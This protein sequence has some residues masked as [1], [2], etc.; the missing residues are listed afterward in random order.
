[1]QATT[2]C[3]NCGTAFTGHYCTNCGEKAFTSHDRSMAH[4]LEEG[5]HFMTHF[6]GKLFT[7]VKTMFTAPGKF[8]LDYC[9]GVRKKYYKPL[10]FFLLLIVIYLLFPVAQGLNAPLP[11]HVQSQWYH[12]EALAK[13][14]AV[15]K[16]HHLTETQ[17]IEHFHT[18]SEKVS[19][20]LLILIIPILALWSKLLAFRRKEKFYYDHFI[21]STEINSFLVL[22]GFLILPVFSRLVLLAIEKLF[23]KDLFN[24]MV[25]GIILSLSIYLYT[26]LAA[27]R[28]FSYVWRRAALYALFFTVVYVLVILYVYQYALFQVTIRLVH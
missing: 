22:W 26:F 6:E 13:T 8:A 15:M 17:V 4:V 25:I 28:F 5:L 14:L 1:M 23:H 19:K 21:L 7:T 24:D 20:V 3:P 11:T 2:N 10:S 27:R 9:Q 12:K 18:V 16:K